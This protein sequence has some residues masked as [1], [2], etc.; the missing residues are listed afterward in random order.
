MPQPP[1]A[2]ARAI[3]GA[4]KPAMPREGEGI[5]RLVHQ[6]DLPVPIGAPATISVPLAHPAFPQTA[7]TPAVQPH[8]F[9]ALVDRLAAAREAVAPQTV[10]VAVSHGEFGPVRLHFHHED[11]ALSVTMASADPDFAR[12]V[13]AAPPIQPVAPASDTAQSQPRD[14]QPRG[15]D[16]SGG[17][18]RGQ[19]RPDQRD[20]RPAR[21][22][23][24]PPR[25]TAHGEPV[26]SG[27][28]A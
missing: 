5:V 25:H 18:S 12:A 15:F 2:D 6:T 13:A 9:A 22:N 4:P 8:D 3:T 7:A 20:D 23:P 24:A 21:S 10:A 19:P 14:T 11:G 17:Q 27:I 26:S 16:Q 1:T 28:F